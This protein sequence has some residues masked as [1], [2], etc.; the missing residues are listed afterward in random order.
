[1]THMSSLARLLRTCHSHVTS[2]CLQ[3]CCVYKLFSQFLFKV[4][5]THWTPVSLLIKQ[6]SA[7][8]S[9][10]YKCSRSFTTKNEQ[11]CTPTSKASNSL[12]SG[13]AQQGDP[14]HTLLFNSLLHIMKPQS[15]KVEQRTAESDLPNVTVT[16]TFPTSGVHRTFFSAA[17]H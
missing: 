14:L 8:R 4:N 15:E 16:Q 1:M 13:G 17:G 2:M 10:T 5:N 7:L 6:A 9:L 11:Q 3:G 12:S